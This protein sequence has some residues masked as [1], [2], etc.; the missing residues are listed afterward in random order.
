M[1]AI[2][3]IDR[4]GHEPNSCSIQMSQIAVLESASPVSLAAAGMHLMDRSCRAGI[5]SRERA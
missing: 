5:R 1:N 4:Q 3:I 2:P